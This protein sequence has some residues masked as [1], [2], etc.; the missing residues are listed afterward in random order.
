MDGWVGWDLCAGLFY[1]HRFA[2]LKI[3]AVPL[4]LQ[5]NI[6]PGPFSKVMFCCHTLQVSGGFQQ[7]C[8]LWCPQRHYKVDRML[9]AVQVQKICLSG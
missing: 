6:M 9:E 7:G 3:W 1:E 5:F 4:I 2:M 8:L